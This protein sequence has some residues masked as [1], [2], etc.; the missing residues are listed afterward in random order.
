MRNSTRKYKKDT[1]TEFLLDCIG[2][3]MWST[4]LSIVHLP[5]HVVTFQVSTRFAKNLMQVFQSEQPT[6]FGSTASVVSAFTE[7]SVFLLLFLYYVL[8]HSFYF[9]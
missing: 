6:Q 5:L 4:M 9:A 7:V 1:K 2:I 3:Q 8:W